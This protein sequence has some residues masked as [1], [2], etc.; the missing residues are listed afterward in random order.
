MTYLNGIIQLM[1][2]KHLIRFSWLPFVFLFLGFFVFYADRT[3]PGI[4]IANTDIGGRSESEVVQLLKNNSVPLQ[5]VHLA[6][7]QNVYKIPGN[8]IDLNYDYSK[9]FDRAY[10]LGRSGNLVFDLSEI[11]T[12]LVKTKNYGYEVSLNND[13][14]N[15][16]LSTIAGQIIVDP[17]FPS[18]KLLNGQIIIDNGKPGNEIDLEGLRTQIGEHLA[19]EDSTNI[20]IPTTQINPSLSKDEADGLKVRAENLIGKKITLKLDSNTESLQDKDLIPLLSVNGV[21][22]NDQLTKIIEE[23]K[24]QFERDPQDAK[25]DFTD[26]KVKEFQPEIDGIQI[27]VVKLRTLL[28]QSIDSL[29]SDKKELTLDIPAIR[30]KAQIKTADVNNL[31]IKELIGHGQSIFFGSIASRI[32]NI[33]LASGKINGTL[34]APGDIFSFDQT[35]GDISA[36]SGYKQAYIISGGKTVL[37]DGGGVCQVSTTLFRAAMN[38]GLPIVERNAHAYRVHYYEE[39]ALPGLDATVYSPTVDFKFKNDT[40]NYILIQTHFDPSKM[41]LSFD[42]YGTSDGRVSTVSKPILSDYVPAPAPLYTDD[43]TL[44]AGEVKQI[45]FSAP[46]TKSR[47]DYTVTRNGQTI[48][49]Q[50]FYSNY[51]AWQAKF[52]RGTGI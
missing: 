38:T 17:V 1:K 32:Y 40:A 41:F 14:L 13:K 19:F 51:R 44:P 6:Y 15:A 9:T 11:L 10:K 34:I 33:G 47:F 52:L 49:N 35:V 16:Y 50:T 29:N 8:E 18:I 4:K 48:Y 12:S 26:G 27:D 46:G 22:N 37:G 3:Y 5:E 7:G 20:D 25:F 21:Y 43:P 24:T 45:D 31:G 36:F 30:Q 42:F 2:K 28:T 23:T 39:D